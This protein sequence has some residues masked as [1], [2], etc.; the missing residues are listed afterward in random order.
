[1]IT[2][3]FNDNSNNV[4]ARLAGFLYLLLAITGTFP[5]IIEEQLVKYGDP[6]TTAANIL[7]SQSLFI[8]SIVSELLMASIWILIGIT[9]YRLFKKVNKNLSFLMVSLVLAGGAIVFISV[10]FQIAAL[11]I[12]TNQTGYLAS[13]NTE[14]LNALMMLF[15]DIAKDSTFSNFIF[16]GLWMF[17]F[18]YLVIKSGYFPK[19]ISLIWGVLLII[20][21]LGYLIDFF[22]YF[23]VPDYF[24]DC[25]RY[26]FSGDLFSLFWLLI[27]GVKTANVTRITESK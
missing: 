5:F 14:Q 13:F 7:S 27:M 2:K 18:A 11:N 19:T 22:T 20:G 16:M 3:I 21:G 9:L 17:P 26:A 4:L 15:L 10:T 1:M 12:I 6:Q 23:L 24:V 25:T 8:T